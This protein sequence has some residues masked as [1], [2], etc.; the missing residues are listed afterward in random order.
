MEIPF[1][2][3]YSKW[4][5]TDV[6]K[7]IEKYEMIPEGS[8]ISVALSGGKDSITLL[9]ILKYLQKYSHLSFHLSAIHI[10]TFSDYDS[11][12]LSNYC[13]SLEVPYFEDRLDTGGRQMKKSVCYMCAR[14]KRGAM[15]RM[16]AEKGIDRA[17]FGHH[18]T[19]VAET[20]LMNIFENKKSGSFS[21]VVGVPG[22]KL[23]IIRP[24]I[25]LE[26]SLI[27][28]LHKSLN[29]PLLDQSCDYGECNVR[30]D[31]KSLIGLM[32]DKLGKKNLALRITASLENV[33]QTNLWKQ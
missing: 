5:V 2:K 21:P 32:E 9:Y 17:A 20:F 29:L 27:T 6:I 33:D 1:N 8:N 3:N 26:E 14:L 16:L 18:A 31:Y 4:F 28:K 19:D 10:K 12:V 15:S 13:E 23:K 30:K 11:S 25:Y 24:M 22:S 7:A